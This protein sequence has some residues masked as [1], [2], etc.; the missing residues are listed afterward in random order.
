MKFPNPARPDKS[1]ALS[2]R[3]SQNVLIFLTIACGPLF[4]GRL[5]AVDSDTRGDFYV[6]PLGN[7]SWTGEL[8]DPNPERADGPFATLDRAR[9]AVRELRK[10]RPNGDVVVLV[11]GGSYRLRETVVFGI[12]D[13]SPLGSTWYRAYPGET[14]IIGSGIPLTAWKKLDADPDNLSPAAQG[15]LW[16]CEAPEELTSILTLYDGWDRL[17]RAQSEGFA[18]A[19]GWPVSRV[20]GRISMTPQTISASARTVRWHEIDTRNG[21]PETWEER[22]PYLHGRFNRVESNDV[23][24][25]MER[26]GDGNCIYVSGTG[27]GNLI[28]GNYLHDVDSDHMVQA[29]RCD[30]DQDETTIEGNVIHN[31][32]SMHEG[33]VSKGK[34]HI[35]NN[36]IVNIIESGLKIK[37]RS[38]CHGY[39]GL[40][41]NPVTG[42][43]IQRNI[44][45]TLRSDYTP[46]IQDRLYGAGGE[47]RLQDCDADYNLY[48]CP[49]DPTWG[50]DH[51]K[52]EREFGIEENSLCAD[53]LFRDLEAGD[54][55]L[56]IHLKIIW[57]F[58][59]TLVA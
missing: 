52:R 2:K 48:F 53:P 46:Y 26:L 45:Y 59:L 20:S 22:E 16:V 31:V 55:R 11:R 25:V 14:P 13:S 43:V 34:N 5:S 3:R 38:Q 42:S 57:I 36:V 17:P 18:P 28:K 50:E 12:E 54:L 23:H 58:S 29:I 30:D 24:H 1:F 21:Q 7:D 47:P 41:V 56:R 4:S 10:T 27:R 40:V 6:S 37:P 19:R 49:G 51:L 15:K 33:I 32:R 8:S 9:S 35:L 39:I 44:L